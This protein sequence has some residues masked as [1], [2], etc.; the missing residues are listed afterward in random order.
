MR[1]TKL[2]VKVITEA[3]RNNFPAGDTLWL[4]GS[5]VD[6]SKRGGDIDLYIETSLTEYNDIFDKRVAFVRK[7]EEKLDEQK[8]DIVINRL[9]LK[10]DL[11]IYREARDTGIQLV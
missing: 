5:R 4:F 10:Q 7:I 1:L 2:E 11:R 3:F 6:D 8:I 9:E